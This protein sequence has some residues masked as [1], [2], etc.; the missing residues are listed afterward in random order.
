MKFVVRVVNGAKVKYFEL[1]YY[2]SA[3]GIR[4]NLH[5]WLPSKLGALEAERLNINSTHKTI[6]YEDF[7]RQLIV[8]RTDIYPLIWLWWWFIYR[9]EES[10][11][12][13]RS[14]FI[15]LAQI[16]GLAYIYP[17]AIPSWRDL[18]RSHER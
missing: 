14:F 9:L 7:S 17:G 5:P 2:P 6:A 3:P 15:H 18:G 11:K 1:I 16:W 8:V 13:C 10:A 12:S 4:V